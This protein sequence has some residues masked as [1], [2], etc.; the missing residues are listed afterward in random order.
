MASLPSGRA[1]C[2]SR[3]D[4]ADAIGWYSSTGGGPELYSGLSM[5]HP[6]ASTWDKWLLT[7]AMAKRDNRLGRML[8]QAH[9]LAPIYHLQWVH[10]L[11]LPLL[12]ML[13][14]IDC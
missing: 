3:D 7:F 12:G 5:V 8:E 9:V 11:G 1:G 13:V 2:G 14:L 10:N 6:F 4:V